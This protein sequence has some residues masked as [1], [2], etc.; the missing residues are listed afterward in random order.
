MPPKFTD[1]HIQNSPYSH[2]HFARASKDK[3]RKM[4]MDI[5]YNKQERFIET[6]KLNTSS[7]DEED[8]KRE[9]LPEMPKKRTKVLKPI[10]KKSIANYAPLSFRN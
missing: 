8:H 2:K 7:D 9:A 6:D 10:D 1:R 3:E 5:L 4:A